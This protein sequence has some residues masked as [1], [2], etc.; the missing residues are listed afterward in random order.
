M[1]DLEKGV[2]I[3]LMDEIWNEGGEQE[4]LAKFTIFS[5]AEEDGKLKELRD[6]LKKNRDCC[7]DDAIDFLIPIDAEK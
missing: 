7:T 2:V 3:D 5:I 1:T 4:E 6:Y